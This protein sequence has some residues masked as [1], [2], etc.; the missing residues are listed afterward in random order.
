MKKESICTKKVDVWQVFIRNAAI[1]GV[2]LNN[3]SEKAFE[4]VR[5]LA[6]TPFTDCSSCTTADGSTGTTD[7]EKTN[8]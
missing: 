2:C 1:F 5:Y 8:N 4:T 6:A 7:D 3:V